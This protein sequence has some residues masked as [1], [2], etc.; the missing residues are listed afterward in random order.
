MKPERSGHCEQEKLNAF[1]RARNLLCGMKIRFPG[2]TDISTDEIC[3]TYAC[4]LQAF[5]FMIRKVPCAEIPDC[6]ILAEKD[7]LN[8]MFEWI[9]VVSSKL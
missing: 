1:L 4:F 2:K 3:R 7:D 9:K 8:H 6:P 5:F